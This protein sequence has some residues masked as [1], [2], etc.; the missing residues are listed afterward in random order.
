MSKWNSL[1]VYIFIILFINFEIHSGYKDG[2]NKS[3]SINKL[4]K[5]GKCDESYQ[6]NLCSNCV[7]KYAKFAGNSS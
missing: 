7:Q 4:S 3:E 5:T 2:M 6:G 1:H